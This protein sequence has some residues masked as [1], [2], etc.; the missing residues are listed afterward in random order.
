MLCPGF[1]YF[2]RTK[3]DIQKELNSPGNL[4]GEQTVKSFEYSIPD[5][6]MTGGVPDMN[7]YDQF[8][9]NACRTR[10]LVDDFYMC[11]VSRSDCEHAL[12]FGMSYLCRS[13]ERH[14]LSEQYA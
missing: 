4:R 6:R 7:S 9:R 5:Q 13:S 8:H 2:V 14:E 12:S 3:I 10:R 11:Q 1:F